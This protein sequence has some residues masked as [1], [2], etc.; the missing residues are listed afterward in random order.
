MSRK[1]ARESTYK[2]IFEFLFSNRANKK[3]FDMFY[4]LELSDRDKEYMVSTYKGVLTHYSELISTIGEFTEN[5]SIDRIF[6]ADLAAL[7]LASYEMLYDESIPHSVSISEAI[8]LV[9]MYSTEKSHQYVNGIL[10]GLYRK[11]TNSTK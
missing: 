6:K 4:A 3:T 9:K 5:F 10:S 2:L 11:L 8:E 1:I 7:L